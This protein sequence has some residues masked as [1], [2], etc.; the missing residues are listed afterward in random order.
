MYAKRHDMTAAYSQQVEDGAT[1]FNLQ[2][3]R[4]SD[5]CRVK[6]KKKEQHPTTD[7]CF[8]EGR[9]RRMICHT[10]DDGS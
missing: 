2:Q 5:C 10:V 1:R 3:N 4:R 7:S 8:M 6:K 9:E